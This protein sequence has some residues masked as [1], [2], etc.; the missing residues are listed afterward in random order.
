MKN[1][2]DN[3]V[4]YRSKSIDKLKSEQLAYIPNIAENQIDYTVRSYL[5]NGK[6]ILINQ[7]TQIC[8]RLNYLRIKPIANKTLMR[9]MNPI[10]RDSVPVLE[11]FN[12]GIICPFIL[13]INGLY[14]PYE[15]MSISIGPEASYLLVD[16]DR[17][18][19]LKS[20]TSEIKYAQILNLPDSVVYKA[21][22]PSIG[23]NVLFSFN[24]QGLYDI[25]EPS[26]SFIANNQSHMYIKA[27]GVEGPITMH[28]INMDIENPENPLF[29]GLKTFKEN[30]ILFAVK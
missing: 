4:K 26:Y 18:E 28:D 27:S 7:A 5:F 14:I 12:N 8:F 21:E 11:L 22:A 6:R 23:D 15:I 2:I 20:L 3:I 19:A 1:V 10:N 25:Y 16:T 13:F 24:A 29:K 30:I 9:Y 17:I